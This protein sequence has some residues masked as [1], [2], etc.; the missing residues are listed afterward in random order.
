MKKNKIADRKEREYHFESNRAV[1]IG[2]FEMLAMA[3][4]DLNYDHVTLVET[5]EKK[6]IVED[7]GVRRKKSRL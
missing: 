2:L 6:T 3:D 5:I 4:T 7:P 1:N